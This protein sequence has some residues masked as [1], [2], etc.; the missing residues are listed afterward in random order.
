MKQTFVLAILIYASLPISALAFALHSGSEVNIS[1]EDIVDENLYVL[2]G[3]INFNKTFEEDLVA[4]GGNSDILGVI[5]GDLYSVSGETRL[6]GEVFGDTRIIS[7]DVYID[8]NTNS[9]L[10]IVSG[11]V[12][13]S[14]DAI[15]NGETM[16]VSGEVDFD[17]Q[18]IG[19]VKIVSGKVNIGGEILGNLEVTTQ[20]LNVLNSSRLRGE[21]VYYSPNEARISEGSVLSHRPVHNQTESIQDNE[22]VKRTVLSF[23]SFWAIIKFLATL[24]TALIL[25]FV[26]RKL[27]QRTAI[28]ATKRPFK[29]LLIGLAS[30][31]L[32]PL[33]ALVLFASLFAL[34]LSVIII[35]IYFISLLIVPAISA[36][37]SGHTLRASHSHL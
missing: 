16:I 12:F 27:S 31:V 11:R 6:K 37:H 25:V 30:L 2:G 15:L 18:A 26:F 3:R 21:V 9:D 20:S 22:F 34:P 24:F 28:L 32:I 8:G 36:I 4:I 17:G 23:I 14:K 5:F 10:M 29:S 1:G 13:V 33:L 19:D 7:G 35:L